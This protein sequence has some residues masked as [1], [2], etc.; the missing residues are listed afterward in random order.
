LAPIAKQ[1]VISIVLSLATNK[2]GTWYFSY[3]RKPR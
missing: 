2:T 1:S 3:G